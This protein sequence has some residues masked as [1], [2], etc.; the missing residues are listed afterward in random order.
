MRAGFEPSCGTG[1]TRRTVLAG[2]AAT[3]LAGCSAE[4]RAE[5][6]PRVGTS[7]YA[8]IRAFGADGNAQRDDRAAFQAALDSLAPKGGTLH[9][10]PGR[11][12]LSGG[13]S[14]AN[15]RFKIACDGAT[16]QA[17]AWDQHLFTF[18][19]CYVETAGRLLLRGP[20]TLFNFIA[21]PPTGREDN[22][23]IYAFLRLIG[24]SH[25][26]AGL[27]GIGMRCL[28]RLDNC[29]NSV[30]E[31][32]VHQGF[33]PDDDRPGPPLARKTPAVYIHGGAGNVVNNP[34]AFDHG[35]I[36]LVTRGSKGGRINGGGGRNLKDNGFYISSGEGWK[37]AG[38]SIERSHGMGVKM[39]G[40]L[41]ELSGGLM[42]N[43][44]VGVSVTGLKILDAQGASGHGNKVSGVT[45]DAYMDGISALQAYG[46]L[47]RDFEIAECRI[48]NQKPEAARTNFAAIRTYVR[49]GF[50]LHDCVIDGT[51]AD[52][53][54][55]IVGDPKQSGRAANITVSANTFGRIARN[56]VVGRK[57]AGPKFDRNRVK[58]ALAPGGKLLVLQD[59]EQ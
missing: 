8:D 45:V 53:A 57:L 40:S 35:S 46:E 54:V 38:P 5:A 52:A 23:D 41:N 26:L 29:A 30:V 6:A 4:P 31:S 13:V 42:K 49:Q 27:D 1:F 15:K 25:R 58:G 2:G 10:P 59:V 17:D 34:R 11:Y 16:L 47:Q 18:R 48:L 19:G 14:A 44:N 3:L 21:F 24:G 51:T 32:P 22:E 28:V 7:T 37:I 55:V 20:D 9:I 39:R 36:V 56:A 33:M 12:R 43:C 50:Y